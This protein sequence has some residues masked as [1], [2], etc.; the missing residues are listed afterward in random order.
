MIKFPSC[1]DLDFSN[2]SRKLIPSFFFNFSKEAILKQFFDF[3]SIS[4]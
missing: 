3:H 2:C 4:F 1:L